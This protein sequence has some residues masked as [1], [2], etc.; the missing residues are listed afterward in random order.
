MFC[1]DDGEKLEPQHDAGDYTDFEPCPTCKVLW[2]YITSL[3]DGHSGY[4]DVSS[5]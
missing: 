1:P 5:E 3:K 2:R 4:L